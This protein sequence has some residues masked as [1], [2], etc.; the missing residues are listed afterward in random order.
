MSFERSRREWRDFLCC[1]IP[2]TTNAALTF[3]VSGE[4]FDFAGWRDMKR[5]FALFLL[6]TFCA[7]TLALADD[8]KMRSSQVDP[9][10]EAR[11]TYHTDRN[12]NT[13]VELSAHHLAPPDQLTPPKT[14][15]VVWIQRPGRDPENLGALKVNEHQEGTIHAT[16]PYKQFD[17]FVTAEDNDRVQTPSTVEVLRGVVNKQ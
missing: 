15:Y 7:A 2:V 12:G 10:A 1:T 14:T 11:V 3:I 4:F 16:T 17:V 8:V 13:T 9:S 6:L 5:V